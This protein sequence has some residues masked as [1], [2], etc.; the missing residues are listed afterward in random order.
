M[1]VFVLAASKNRSVSA[2]EFVKGG[3]VEVV[4]F[5]VEVLVVARGAGSGGV[6]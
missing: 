5:G 3:G 2:A 4:S 1:A 6:D